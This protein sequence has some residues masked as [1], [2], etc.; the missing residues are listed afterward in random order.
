MQG[1]ENSH[2][3]IWSRG[4]PQSGGGG[5]SSGL[6]D[7]FEVEGRFPEPA[8]PVFILRVPPPVTFRLC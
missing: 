4:S 2:G 8:G 1:S 7:V 6:G 3:A 5:L